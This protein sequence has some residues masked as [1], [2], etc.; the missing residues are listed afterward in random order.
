MSKIW[1]AYHSRRFYYFNNRYKLKNAAFLLSQGIDLYVISQRLGH[2]DMT[3]TA[4]IYAYLIDEYKQKSDDR[5]VNQLQSI[6]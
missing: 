3:T 5:I 1:G 2:S 6:L 4:K